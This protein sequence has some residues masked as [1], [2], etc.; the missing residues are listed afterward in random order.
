M[1]SDL[2]RPSLEGMAELTVQ[3]GAPIE[4]GDTPACVEMAFYRVT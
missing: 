2:V 1:A 4:I 3:V